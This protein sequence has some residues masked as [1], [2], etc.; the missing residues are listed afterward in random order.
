[1]AGQ[2]SRSRFLDP[3]ET[4]YPLWGCVDQGTVEAG[5]LG[6]QGQ[7][8][9]LLLEQGLGVRLRVG[10]PLGQ[11]DDPPAAQCVSPRG[12]GLRSAPGQV[13]T[14]SQQPG[15]PPGFQGTP[16]PAHSLFAFLVN[17]IYLIPVGEQKES[18]MQGAV[19]PGGKP[20]GRGGGGWEGKEPGSLLLPHHPC[21]P[22]GEAAFPH[23][24]DGYH[25][26]PRRVW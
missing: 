14:P 12:R 13:G 21:R 17:V 2:V 22:P 5:G 16:L 6:I 26:Q 24:A 3:G 25:W 20:S 8:Q 19:Q 15:C 9:L 7:H 18:R 10:L 11:W 4:P 23:P 1:M